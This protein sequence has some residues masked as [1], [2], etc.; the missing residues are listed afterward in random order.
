[1]SEGKIADRRNRRLKQFFSSLS[2]DISESQIIK[3]R[4]SGI[5]SSGLKRG[6]LGTIFAE[7]E[8]QVKSVI[9][10][11][12]RLS[13]AVAPVSTGLN[14]G[15]GDSFPES[16]Q[17]VTLDLRRMKRISALC[18]Q[19]DRVSIEPG[20]SQGDLKEFLAKNAPEYQ[21][22]QTFW[23]PESSVIGNA[24]ERGRTL[25]FERER[26]LIGSKIVTGSGEYLRTGFNPDSKS[27]ICGGLNLHPMIFQSNLGVVVEGVI[28][29]RLADKSA[30]YYLIGFNS[31]Q[32]FLKGMDGLRGA[33]SAR[34]RML[35]WLC[36][37]SYAHA[38]TASESHA[39]L[40]SCA[41]GVLIVETDRS[42]RA[43]ELA[44]WTN[45]TV[46]Q[47]KRELLTQ[48]A[49]LISLKSAASL[50]N[51]CFFSFSVKKSSS[52]LREAKRLIE[53][54]KS[55]YSVKIYRTLS[56]LDSVAILLLRVELEPHESGSQRKNC[57]GS[58][59]DEIENAGYDLYRSHS[60]LPIQSGGQGR[61]QNSLKKCFD[62]NQIISPGRYGL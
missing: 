60:G 38:P 39:S 28:R 62:P 46:V 3:E 8:A 32:S 5:D 11:A 21:F 40:V 19:E 43:S 4:S 47:I 45:G 41:G 34:Q 58:I 53:K 29:L 52:G 17:Q 14:V 42:T 23:L 35:R 30:R 33:H 27:P 15:Y 49:S 16:S 18:R 7:N 22:D 55:R 12:N 13:I 2:A 50:K 31:F 10:N 9:Q 57:L 6:R 26:D 54:I 37:S 59:A 1:V 20:V 36:P 25:F 56:F 48:E 51:I 61:L 24:L 44:K